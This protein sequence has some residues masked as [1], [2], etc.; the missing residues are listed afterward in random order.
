MYALGFDIEVDSLHVK[1]HNQKRERYFFGM[2][3][4]NKLIG[5]IDPKLLIFAHIMASSFTNTPHIGNYCFICIILRHHKP[6]EF[7]FVFRL[8]QFSTEKIK[9]IKR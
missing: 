4:P 1:D 9:K 8:F 3:G 6:R 7:F 2:F 5:G